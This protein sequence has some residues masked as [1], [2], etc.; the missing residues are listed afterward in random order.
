MRRHTHT[1]TRERRDE[2][3][4]TTCSSSPRSQGNTQTQTGNP[5][6]TQTQSPSTFHRALEQLLLC[7]LLIPA[8][9]CLFPACLPPALTW[10][11]LVSRL[12]SLRFW[13]RF[14]SIHDF[15]TNSKRSPLAKWSVLPFFVPC[16]TKQ[17]DGAGAAEH[18]MARH[19]TA[20]WAESS[21]WA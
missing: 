19:G 9:A 12:A 8:P 17:G 4:S 3:D 10:P 21:A 20:Q 7:L 2:T 11:Q 16:S 5:T 14:V 6:Q 1:H 15:R 18:G 13:F